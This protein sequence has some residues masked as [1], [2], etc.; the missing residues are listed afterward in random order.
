MK[1]SLLQRMRTATRLAWPHITVQV[2]GLSPTVLS[3]FPAHPS[4]LST[5]PLSLSSTSWPLLAGNDTDITPIVSPKGV[6]DKDNSPASAVLSASTCCTQSHL[7][8]GAPSLDPPIAIPLILERNLGFVGDHS[9]LITGSLSGRVTKRRRLLLTDGGEGAAGT[10]QE[11]S[12]EGVTG[13]AAQEASEPPPLVNLDLS[14]PAPALKPVVTLMRPGGLQRQGSSSAEGFKRRRP[15]DRGDG[16]SFPP[17]L[18]DS[19][20]TLVDADNP[21]PVTEASPQELMLQDFNL[22]VRAG[23]GLR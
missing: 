15:A 10:A 17:P 22:E 21:A 1:T 12:G 11:T 2:G 19:D 3:S 8:E 20:E 7:L 6:D 4:A 14:I 18:L 16:P 5:C 23:S 13:T 9:S